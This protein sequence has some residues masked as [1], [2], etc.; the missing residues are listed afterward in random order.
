MANI[1]VYPDKLPCDTGGSFVV[2]LSKALPV[3][4]TEFSLIFEGISS[5]NRISGKAVPVDTKTLIGT[6]GGYGKPE[7][8]SVEVVGTKGGTRVPSFSMTFLSRFQLISS[9]FPDDILLQAPVA[10]ARCLPIYAEDIQGV[11]EELAEFC[12]RNMPVDL[13]FRHFFGSDLDEKMGSKGTLLHFAAENGLAHFAAHLLAA[14]G[15]AWEALHTQ[16]KEGLTPAEVAYQKQ[17]NEIQQLFADFEDVAADNAVPL[18]EYGNLQELMG[19]DYLKVEPKK[20]Q[21][22]KDIK[23]KKKSLLARIVTERRSVKEGKKKGSG[24]RSKRKSL[25]RQLDLHHIKKSLGKVGSVTMNKIRKITQKDSNENL[26]RE[27]SEQSL[28]STSLVSLSKGSQGARA[29]PPIPMEDRR[30][31]EYCDMD[32]DDFD[33][34][35]TYEEVE[36]SCRHEQPQSLMRPNMERVVTRA[37]SLIDYRP[38]LRDPP[39][40]LKLKV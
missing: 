13:S 37:I 3:N 17:D 40:S 10:V 6:V 20:A 35:Q 19:S 29:L 33:G 23:R 9:F 27:D 5:K 15:G 38:G 25:F 2:V 21:I 32:D 11:D 18:V 30:Q 24:E 16:N 7:E 22:P 12:Q 1:H 34:E 39:D 14:S 26:A 31:Q 8:V 4:V 36:V 28:S